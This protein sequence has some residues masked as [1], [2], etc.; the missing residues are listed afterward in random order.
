MRNGRPRCAPFR[1]A[2]AQ[3]DERGSV[4]ARR[5]ASRASSTAATSPAGAIDR[6]RRRTRRARALAG[7]GSERRRLADRDGACHVR[8]PDRDAGRPLRGDRRRLVVTAPREYRK[9]QQLFTTREFPKDFVLKLEFR[10]TPE[11]RQRR[12]PAR[13]AAPVPRLPARR[14]L[15]EPE[16]LQA[17]GLERARRQRQGRRGP[18]TCNGELLE[19]AI[20]LP[21]SGPIGVEGDRGQMEYRRIGSGSCRASVGSRKRADGRGPRAGPPSA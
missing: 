18:S 11:R 16:E 7:L 9:I 8:R 12:L 5:R 21:A 6:R 20:A 3:R 17:A 1:D 19:A 4:H 14:P 10:A 13:A 2:G 15:Q